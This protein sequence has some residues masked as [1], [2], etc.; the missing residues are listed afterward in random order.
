MSPAAFTRGNTA[1]LPPDLIQLDDLEKLERLRQETGNK[2]L[3]AE[4]EA[5]VTKAYGS[6]ALYDDFKV[7]IGISA[8]QAE[9]FERFGKCLQPKQME[10]VV[11]ARKLDTTTALD[12]ES[13]APELGMGGAKGPGK[14]FALFAQMALDDCQ[15]F[16]G[17][18]CLYLRKTGIK[19]KEQIEDLIGSVLAGVPHTFANERIRFPNGSTIRIGHYN[20]EK[21]AMSYAGIEYDV[22]VIEET[23]QLSLKAYTA[24]RGSARSSKNWRPRIYNSTNP[25]GVGHTWYKQRFIEHERKHVKDTNRTRKFIFATVEDN[26]FVNDDYRGTLEELTGVERRAFLEGDWDV[27]AGA[28]FECFR[29]KH[30]VIT[31]FYD[32]AWMRRIW[33]SM[34]YGFHHWNMTYLHAQD[35]DGNKYTLHELAHRKRYPADIAPDIFEMLSLYGLTIKDVKAFKIGADAFNKTGLSEFSIVDQY[36]KL[37]IRMTH[38]ETAAGSR[39]G[40]AQYMSTLLGDPEHGKINRWWITENCPRLIDCLGSLE[41][42][43]NNMEDVMKVDADENGV[44]GDDGYDGARY[45]IYTPRS[46]RMSGQS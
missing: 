7:K 12:D 29:R 40:G 45:G 27:S 18:K 13:G 46:V 41:R 23:T 42:D 22:I 39:I 28:F 15:R 32:V 21:E 25:L 24:L 35:G 6:R 16:P 2:K 4:F 30:H 8:E 3:Q 26:K 20:T 19:A 43:P 1:G 5:R 33:M 11:W 31:P 17:L 38:A 44:G 10:F 37:G 36:R 34:D 14:S 9:N